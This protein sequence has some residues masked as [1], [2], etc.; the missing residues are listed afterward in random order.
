MMLFALMFS[1]SFAVPQLTHAQDASADSTNTQQMEQE[2]SE[3]PAKDEQKSKKKKSKKDKKDGESFLQKLMFWKKNKAPE[4]ASPW[5]EKVKTYVAAKE[6][7]YYRYGY[8]QLDSG[9]WIPVF[10]LRRFKMMQRQYQHILIIQGEPARKPN[11]KGVEMT[12]YGMRVENQGFDVEMPKF[13][14]V[15]RNQK[16]VDEQEAIQLATIQLDLYGFE[17]VIWLSDKRK[18]LRD[19]ADTWGK[20]GGN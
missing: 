11:I 18:D 8:A 4:D 20:E 3:A 6:T 14:S 19:L 9:D 13:A 15:S 12:T 17:E 7:E 1:L 10:F 5:H 2:E 16:K